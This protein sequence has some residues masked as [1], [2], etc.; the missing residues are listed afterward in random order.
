MAK[1]DLVFPKFDFD[2]FL[3]SDMKVDDMCLEKI[4][5]MRSLGY[6]CAT[7]QED[8]KLKQENME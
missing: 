1:L 4:E 8:I 3:F 6:C 7:A 5:T 2:L